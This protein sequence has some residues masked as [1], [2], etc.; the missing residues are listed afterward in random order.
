[1]HER[2]SCAHEVRE[3]LV[4]LLEKG[5]VED[6]DLHARL[7]QKVYTA[8]AHLGVGI[9]MPGYDPLYPCPQDRIRTRGSFTVV[10]TGLERHVQLRSLGLPP[11][12]FEGR[13]LRVV[14]PSTGMP[15]LPDHRAVAHHDRPY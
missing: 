13:D 6:L 11:R 12:A 5:I 3:L 10:V 8:T 7:A 9:Q 15:A 4:L 1:V 14:A 2:P